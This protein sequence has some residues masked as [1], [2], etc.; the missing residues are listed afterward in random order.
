M[1]E[2]QGPSASTRYFS[3]DGSQISSLV[4]VVLGYAI[5]RWHERGYAARTDYS[6][7]VLTD[8]LQISI[9]GENRIEVVARV[10]RVCREQLQFVG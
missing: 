2:C 8:C 5:R 4:S 7:A 1:H 10:C 9:G 3:K 6:V